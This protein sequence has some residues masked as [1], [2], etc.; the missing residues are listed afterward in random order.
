MAKSNKEPQKLG[1]SGL[2]TKWSV[3]VQLIGTFGLAVFLVLYYLFVMGPEENKR[4]DKLNTSINEHNTS[5]TELTEKVD[6]IAEVVR[7][8]QIILKENQSNL[9]EKLFTKC[10][11]YEIAD[12]IIKYR[13]GLIDPL[14]I[15]KNL[16]NILIIK[17]ELA[18]GLLYAN[19]S[20]IVKVL[21]NIILKN[22]I[23]KKIAKY[24]KNAIAMDSNW[25]QSSREDLSDA[26][27]GDILA[28][29]VRE[30]FN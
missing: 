6:N 17:T 22:E 19:G 5:I 20:K 2:P 14:D 3:A 10:V 26:I 16:E 8:N 25:S 24:V 7:G 9:L 13:S 11:A 28:Y 21:K 4:Y 27:I 15:Q 30:K 23:A 12:S 18:E 29:I 1:I